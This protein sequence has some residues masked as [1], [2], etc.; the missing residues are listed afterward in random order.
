[1]LNDEDD[2]LIEQL[3]LS[4]HGTTTLNNVFTNPK[5]P[6]GEDAEA[7]ENSRKGASEAV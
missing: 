1:M 5:Q 4:K 6:N 2:L 7:T 3:M